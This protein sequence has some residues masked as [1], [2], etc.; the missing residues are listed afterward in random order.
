MANPFLEDFLKDL[1]DME[2]EKTSFGGT[3]QAS[4]FLPSPE[5]PQ[6][7]KNVLYDIIGS[8]AWAFADEAA[9]GGLSLGAYALD[10]DVSQFA[11][12]TLPGK[13]GAGVGALGGFALGAP[14]KVGSKILTTAA[15]PFLQK[16]AAELGEDIV[17]SSA[18]TIAK[19]A[20]K[21]A[22]DTGLR[23][24]I[25][26]DF[27]N[28][29]LNL[30][31]RSTFNK[32]IAKDFVLRSSKS[33]DDLAE[34]YVKSGKMTAAEADIARNVF[35]RDL[36]KRPIQNFKDLWGAQG[37][38]PWVGNLLDEA[39]MFTA[40][41]AIREV[42]AS[43]SQERPYDFMMPV[44]GTVVGA[45]FGGI[46][47][48]NPVGKSSNFR[49]E[50]AD[51]IRSAF[52]RNIYAN[53]K[54]KELKKHATWLAGQMQDNADEMLKTSKRVNLNGKEYKLDLMMPDQ[55]FSDYG[56]KIGTAVLRKGLD[57]YSKSY[58]KELLKWSLKEEWG[59]LTE[60]WF[61]MFAGGM[62]MN[63][64]ALYQ[65]AVNDVELSAED[66]IPGMLIG[67]WMNRNG[68]P[69]AFDLNTRTNRVRKNLHMLGHD[70][71]NM[72]DIPSFSPYNAA[73][74]NPI[75]QNEALLKVRN[76]AEELGI[77][78]DSYEQSIANI[79]DG[80]TS[81]LFEHQSR[82]NYDVF[83][84]FYHLLGG[85]KKFIK[86]LDQI[87]VDEANL[88]QNSIKELKW[89]ALN[90]RS[91]ENAQDLYHVVESISEG[92]AG[93]FEK[94]LLN[95]LVDMKIDLP[96]LIAELD[97]S[98]GSAGS[99]PKKF[100]IPEVSLDTGLPTLSEMAESGRLISGLEGDAAIRRLK[101]V[102]LKA[103]RIID[104]LETTN[105]IEKTD[106][107]FK[108]TNKDQF[109]A[110][111]NIIDGFESKVNQSVGSKEGLEFDILKNMEDME[112]VMVA[113]SA[114]TSAK[115][116]STL[117]AQGSKS[118]IELQT[119]LKNAGILHGDNLVEGGLVSIPDLSLQSIE[120]TG[121]SETK[122]AESR[123]SLGQVLSIIKAKA[124]YTKSVPAEPLKIDVS[125][126]DNLMSFLGK[127]G[128]KTKPWIMD[129]WN[130]YTLRYIMNENIEGSNI[131]MQDMSTFMDISSIEGLDLAKV[132]PKGRGFEARRIEM[133]PSDNE[134][135]IAQVDRYNT[136]IDKIVKDGKSVKGG[137]ISEGDP[138]TVVGPDM[139]HIIDQKLD[140]S[141]ADAFTSA[142]QAITDF[143]NSVSINQPAFIE[144]MRSFSSMNADYAKR[145]EGWLISSKVISRERPD[146]YIKYRFNEDGLTDEVID[147]LKGKMNLYGVS[148]DHIDAQYKQNREE[149]ME[150]MEE[151]YAQPHADGSLTQD[152]F[153]NKY[154]VDEGGN[155]IHPDKM[156]QD[157]ILSLVNQVNL[158]LAAKGM[159]KKLNVREYVRENFRFP[160]KTNKGIEYKLGSDLDLRSVKNKNMISEAMDH[161]SSIIS[162]KT[163]ATEGH[164][165]MWDG[166]ASTFKKM[167]M[168]KTKFTDAMEKYNLP[169]IFISGSGENFG[170]WGT[171]RQRRR[172]SLFETDSKYL[173]DKDKQI[174]RA[175]RLNFE[176]ELSA[177]TDVYGRVSKDQYEEG[178]LSLSSTDN[179]GVDIFVIADKI[180]PV[181]IGRSN[182]PLLTEAYESLFKKVKSSLGDSKAKEMQDN[183]DSMKR[184]PNMKTGA[185]EQALRQLLFS[186]ISIE[187]NDYSGFA[188]LM[189]DVDFGD[190]GNIGK[191]SKRLSLFH[192]PNFKKLNTI[193]TEGAARN[194]NDTR[195]IEKYTKRLD[196]KVRV[197]IL[198]DDKNNSN[199][200]IKQRLKKQFE[201]K[202]GDKEGATRFDNFWA[203]ELHGRSDETRLDSVSFLSRDMMRYF[204]LG[205][206]RAAAD[207]TQLFKPVISS[208]GDVL[209]LGKTVFVHDPDLESFFKTQGLDILTTGSAS[210]VVG[211]G[212]NKLQSD[213]LTDRSADISSS[214]R[215][216]DMDNIRIKQ[217]RVHTED[218]AKQSQ[219]AFNYMSSAEAEVMFNEGYATQL[220]NNLEAMNQ[221]FNNP[222]M[223]KMFFDQT[224]FEDQSIQSMFEGGEGGAV[225]GSAKF[226]ASNGMDPLELGER[227]FASQLYRKFVDPIVNKKAEINGSRYGG[228]AVLM[229]SLT[230]D[231]NLRATIV[232]DGTLT[233][234]GQVVLP[235]YEI[236]SKLSAIKEQTGMS[237]KVIR[238]SDQ[239]VL[240]ISELP[241]I[242]GSKNVGTKNPLSKEELSEM[243]LGHLHKLV[244][245]GGEYEVAI[246]TNRYPRTRPNDMAVLGLKGFLTKDHGNAMIVNEMDVLNIFEGDYD[247]DKNDYYFMQSDQMF[248]HIE[249]RMPSWAQGIDVDQFA[250]NI[251]NLSLSGTARTSNMAWSQ[252]LGNA[253]TLKKGIGVTQ[254]L[255][256][257]LNWIRDLAEQKVINKD[258]GETEYVLL[259]KEDGSR[260]VMDYDNKDWWHRAVLETQAIIDAGTSTS[261]N[262]INENMRDY[263]DDFLFPL[264]EE[265]HSY[266]EKLSSD[267]NRIGFLRDVAKQTP[268]TKRIRLFRKL[269]ADGT[270]TSDL[271]GVDKDI[272]K[273]LLD[274]YSKFI[275]IG[276]T[277]FDKTGNGKK[278]GYHDVMDISEEY[279]TFMQ[280][281]GKG[282]DMSRRMFYKLLG[283]HGNNAEFAQY[284]GKDKTDAY[285]KDDKEIPSYPINT[286]S[287][288]PEAMLNKADKI[289]R[290]KH[291]NVLDRMMNKVRARDPLGINEYKAFNQADLIFMDEASNRFM[292]N[293]EHKQQF[294]EDVLAYTQD[295][296]KKISQ[297][298]YLKRRFGFINNMKVSAGRKQ[299]L[300]NDLNETIRSI[301][302][303]I[304]DA[305]PDK[306]KKTFKGEDLKA[307]YIKI[308]DLQSNKEMQNA[309]VQLYAMDAIARINDSTPAMK[310]KIQDLHHLERRMFGDMNDLSHTQ[311]YGDATV[312]SDRINQ[313]LKS[314]KLDYNNI[315]SVISDM[316]RSGV[317][318]HGLHFLWHYAN[319]KKNASAVGVFNN[320]VIPVPYSG[321]GRMKRVIRHLADMAQNP[322]AG[323]DPDA[324]NAFRALGSVVGHYRNYFNKNWE[325]LSQDPIINDQISYL[326]KPSQNS[327]DGLTYEHLKFP[328]FS[329][330]FESGLDGFKAYKWKKHADVDDPFKTQVDMPVMSFYKQ[331]FELHGK[332]A[333]FDQYVNQK[334]VLHKELESNRIIDPMR[335]LAMVSNLDTE[336]H[337]F[338][339]NK[340]A[341]A[342]VD[343]GGQAKVW[344]MDQIK[345]KD[346]MRGNIIYALMG[347]NKHFKT[348][349]LAPESKRTKR[350]LSSA[351]EFGKFGQTVIEKVPEGTMDNLKSSFM[352]CTVKGNK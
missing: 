298:R 256:R 206:G 306:Y 21:E 132:S 10:Q 194:S 84:S 217:D 234:Y 242:R 252:Q 288:F 341:G 71:R 77:I 215:Q 50:M 70:V 156:S 319:P 56:D 271:S 166:G 224:A 285:N 329:S 83:N 262:L 23:K 148:Y 11:P 321:N 291:G 350:D 265:S 89:D 120:I 178:R 181:G 26:D 208:T 277:I 192:T 332:G 45:G 331:F 185:H 279:F 136:F 303:T 59:S 153:F 276:S 260:I 235:E 223:R 221:V 316:I 337:N 263:R 282:G 38:N 167:P 137:L 110:L 226:A 186:E 187:G 158:D 99:F 27:T 3:E 293:P 197:A 295:V 139:M 112:T 122:I 52:G 142:K 289:A 205:T 114:K 44:I 266:L 31:N 249:N 246:V 175:N 106:K 168:Q 177:I 15:R 14:L 231:T 144:Q 108:L 35:Q 171:K 326:S 203:N 24:E 253:S 174:I 6:E 102:A 179:P 159:A 2:Q 123:R 1:Q 287:P 241:L 348:L 232:E 100:G 297:I 269:N 286:R 73:Y 16:A 352:H 307:G 333:E 145:L 62:V 238:T 322:Q 79:E 210:K 351:A 88:L 40:I 37:R 188:S 345:D 12:Q 42:P 204:S 104:A 176:K 336:L 87:S 299:E 190:N 245:T 236:D 82:G 34:S 151:T 130:G 30:S 346:A 196:N 311:E 131:T 119:A 107:E 312:V 101:N 19:K 140:Y 250:G 149:Y 61:R 338:A 199:F 48:L 310:S 4:L 25:A 41:D 180:Q 67:A 103:N 324:L 340:Y 105:R 154:Y 323:S 49:V 78:T 57:Q 258:T 113:N 129:Q 55:V 193:I 240:D 209:L 155:S 349:T 219:S 150:I 94:S 184:S 304:A 95:T 32:D 91:V 111:S 327:P 173:T 320:Q 58:G 325:Y 302:A 344:S 330:R 117:F 191:I 128:M 80:S 230:G 7:E 165:V 86:G 141:H 17:V 318:E 294:N 243:T 18:K 22:V 218:T 29:Y 97:P 69:R 222:D 169:L 214:I 268:G 207:E 39:I 315:E 115:N 46:K 109:E 270:E 313:Y 257:T 127:T 189:N 164:L 342:V 261:S 244:N 74:M 225:L 68:T 200:S 47:F 201:D 85:Q 96:G 233:Q 5:Q 198:D 133:P 147:L 163:N 157:N 13:I 90:N 134:V 76:K 182:L 343:E 63:A 301:E 259:Q 220:N 227:L 248:K 314:A 272:I 162:A 247:V 118:H 239:K 60:N 300:K 72:V 160:V 8:S 237:I 328:S 339:K 211:A 255:H 183:I 228:K 283:T 9:F 170:G 125:Q 66:M 212:W 292:E 229:Q 33:V 335:Y 20:S 267:T 146:G 53:K 275:S 308:V 254:K 75:S 93:V 43:I 36:T 280:N 135:L 98:I 264:R 116:I 51:G 152:Q 296:N 334:S 347:G 28:Q 273:T 143:T 202:Y 81:V 274:Q 54:P 305:L 195:I 64:H 92:A 281:Y 65:V 309:A 126:V 124:Q 251:E 172:V 138:L 216:I 161:F 278:P 213:Q 290:G 317:R 284:F 121:G